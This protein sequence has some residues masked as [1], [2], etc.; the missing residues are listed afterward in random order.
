MQDYRGRTGRGAQ[1][2][3][4]TIVV[5]PPPPVADDEPIGASAPVAGHVVVLGDVRGVAGG[6]RGVIPLRRVVVGG[7]IEVGADVVAEFVV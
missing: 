7:G 2:A 5:V 6:D 3:R 4:A 1:A